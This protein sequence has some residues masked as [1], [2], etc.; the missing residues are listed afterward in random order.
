MVKSIYSVSLSQ[1][2]FTTKGKEANDT[3]EP[4]KAI[5]FGTESVF[6]LILKSSH[7]IFMSDSCSH[8]YIHTRIDMYTHMQ[9]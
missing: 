1:D 7:V 6:S 2:Y 3:S 9:T 4:T 8:I 5:R